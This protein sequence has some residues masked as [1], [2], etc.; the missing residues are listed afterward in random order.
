MLTIVAPALGARAKGQGP[1]D[2]D[3][4]RAAVFTAEA[5]LSVVLARFEMPLARAATLKVDDRID[6]PGNE[7]SKVALEGGEGMPELPATLGQMNGKWAIRLAH[8]AAAQAEA[9]SPVFADKSPPPVAALADLPETAT[10][11]TGLP[12]LPELPDLP[13]LPDG[14]GLHGLPELSDHQTS[15]PDLPTPA[16]DPA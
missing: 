7:P 2:T 3:R 13:D 10:E 9:I 14:P 15:L 12:E 8:A 4:L 1:I 6:L 11:H 16:S 5:E